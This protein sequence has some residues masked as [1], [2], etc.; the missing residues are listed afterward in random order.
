V[1]PAQFQN[2]ERKRKKE[3]TKKREYERI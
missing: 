1:T 2:K 3:E